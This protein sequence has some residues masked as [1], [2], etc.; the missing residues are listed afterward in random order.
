M[1]SRAPRSDALRNRERILAAA[2]E[3]FAKQGADVALDV[4]AE[5]AGVGPGTLHRHF[6]TKQAILAAVIANRLNDLAGHAAELGGDPAEDFFTFLSEL[7]DSGR[8]NLALASALGG[9][10]NSLIEQSAARLSAALQALLVAAQRS[11]DVRPDVGV[12]EVHAILTGVLAT[13]SR[14]PENRRGLGLQIAI[15]GLR[16]GATG[17]VPYP[18]GEL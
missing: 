2:R 15:D 5:A 8:D 4:I 17:Q 12:A 16:T 10:P 6:P 3:V 13:E 18:S 7:V 14:L 1:S 11:G 9:L